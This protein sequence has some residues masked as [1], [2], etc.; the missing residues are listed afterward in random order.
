MNKPMDT[1]S[2]PSPPV[3]SL[4]ELEFFYNSIFENEVLPYGELQQV[5]IFLSNLVDAF[6]AVERLILQEQIIPTFKAAP[7]D[8]KAEIIGKVIRLA[9]EHGVDCGKDGHDAQLMEKAFAAF[10]EEVNHGKAGKGR[11]VFVTHSPYFVILREAMNL[12][13]KGYR[14]FL[15]TIWPIPE[16][17]GRLFKDCFDGIAYTY[18]CIRVMRR[19]LASLEPDIFHVQCWMMFYFLGRLAIENRKSAAVVCE[20]YDI[21][22]VYADR[23]TLCTNWPVQSVDF[24]LEMERFIL[25]EANAVIH[26]FP[27]D[28][29]A[30][31]RERHGAMP[32]EIEM[33]AYACQ[34]F[35]AYCEDKMSHADGIP[36]VVYAGGIVPYSKRYSLE[37]FPERGMIH[38]FRHLLELG[39][40]VVVFP[41]PHSPVE[42]DDPEY[43]PY[44]E[45]V[46]EFPRFSILGSVPPDRLAREISVYDYGLLL[47][48]MDFNVLRV[49]NSLLR[50]AVGTKLFAYL[51][52]GLPVLVNAEYKEM[53]RIVTEHGMGM[54]VHTSELGNLA[55]IL[56]NFDYNQAVENIRR[57]NEE[58]AMHLEVERVIA[59]YEEIRPR[60]P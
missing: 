29:V 37:L 58:H 17:L 45:L 15:A 44:F 24:D 4:A 9:K 21:T 12:R 28:V 3:T 46:E 14:V 49:S 5:E 48:K 27:R 43:A 30:E 10:I 51:E 60:N 26:R 56:D 19:L 35:T 57:F 54:A 22:S 55:E 2:P 33:Q 41:S 53:S 40:E 20:F 18:G 6:P 32:P 59:L 13:R 31:W 23:A 34:E 36:R 7:R 25:H 50:G 11:V 38:V 1:S 8:M 52:A 16:E 39:L 47:S 42:G